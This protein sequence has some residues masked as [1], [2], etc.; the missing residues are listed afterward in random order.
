[1][2]P[3]P[4]NATPYASPDDAAARDREALRFWTLGSGSKGNAT[5][6]VHRGVGLLVDAGFELP[7]LVH[8]IRQAGVAPAD[9]EHVV[10][11]HGHRDHVLGAA[12]GARVYGWS[13]W[14]T[15]GTVWRWRALREVPLLPFEPGDAFDAPPFHVAT[16]P[17][18][19]DIDD[20][21]A[22]VVAVPASGARVGVCTDL[23]EA[24]PP[25]R[26]LLAG[27][28]ALVVESNHDPDL[29]ARGPYPEDVRARVA[30]PHGHLSNAEAAALA[31]D[32]VTASTAAVVLAHISRHNNTPALALETMR[33][34]LAGTA[35]RG[36]IV[37]A[38]QD[39]VLG[40]FV[41]AARGASAEQGAAHGA[42]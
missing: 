19:H 17:T 4:V 23:G 6:F 18:P 31:R 13:L 10:L 7:E 40:P 39:E 36:A 24:P 25:V 20:S 32:V 26:S 33:A 3:A 1:M 41:V 15:L 14:G 2:P 30:G 29:L 8:R 28:D 34:A 37:A 12:D 11:T 35:F 22:I 42:A 38:P 9:V 5:L 21:S 27:C 16:A